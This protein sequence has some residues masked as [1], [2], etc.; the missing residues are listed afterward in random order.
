MPSA[1][2]EPC[3]PSSPA[4]R[5]APSLQGT[6][7]PSRFPGRAGRFV[8]GA[9]DRSLLS[10]IASPFPEGITKYDFSHQG[11]EPV[12]LP[13]DALDNLFQITVVG[14]L[15]ATPHRVG[16]ELLRQVTDELVL[17]ELQDRNQLHRAIEPL[18]AWHLAG[19]VHGGVAVPRAPAADR[20]EILQSE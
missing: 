1:A 17:P 4:R 13:G 19:R 6:A 2:G 11:R 3:R 18:A 20:I 7:A 5:A 9:V 12:V 16:E 10:S 15:H 8:G 14:A